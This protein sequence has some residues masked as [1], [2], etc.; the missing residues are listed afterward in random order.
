MELKIDSMGMES[1]LSKMSDD[2]LLKIDSSISKILEKRNN[3][4]KEKAWL[5]VRDAIFDYCENYGSIK[6][7]G[8]Y[9]F[10]IDSTDD[11]ST[12]GAIK[13]F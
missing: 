12:I 11:F 1:S 6:I 10:S 9:A 8:D 3:Q 2:E 4:K 5:A 7:F 13:E